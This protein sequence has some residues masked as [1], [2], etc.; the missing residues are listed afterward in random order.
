MKVE[1]GTSTLLPGFTQSPKVLPKLSLP[2]CP[3]VILVIPVI[4]VPLSPCPVSS[5]SCMQEGIEAL[6]LALGDEEGKASEAKA[7][8]SEALKPRRYR[9]RDS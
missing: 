8:G 1:G 9:G 5:R 4:P 6:D 7:Q 3:P 2:P